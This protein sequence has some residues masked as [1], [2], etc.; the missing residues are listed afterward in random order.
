MRVQSARAGVLFAITLLL[1][2]QVRAADLRDLLRRSATVEQELS[3]QGRKVLTRSLDGGDVSTT[4]YKVYHRAPDRTL[5]E[6]VDGD[7]EGVR[8]VQ[9]GREH[10]LHSKYDSAYR[11]PPLALPPDNTDLLLRNYTIRQMRVEQIARRKCV[12]MALEPKHPG[13]PT[14]LVWLDVETALPLKTQMRGPDG[15]LTE[16][17]QFLLIDYHAQISQSIFTLRG[18]VVGEWPTVN[19]DFEIVYVRKG[20]LPVGYSLRET[21]VRRSAKGQVLAFLIYS[22]GLNTLTLIESKTHHDPGMVGGSPSV[23]G[24]VGNVYF[25]ICGDHAATV[26]L[27]MGKALG[28][29]ATVT[30]VRRASRWKNVSIQSSRR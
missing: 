21:Q 6:G 25:A 20:G 15:S 10:Y 18:P 22:D 28:K 12:M 9:I 3:Y 5:M 16:E 27:R 1:V 30:L 2:S 26:L 13:N 24:K 17:S 11:R 23:K 29:H 4:T 8:L 7:H 19:P 14:K